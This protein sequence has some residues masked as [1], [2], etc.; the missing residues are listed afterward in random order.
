MYDVDTVIITFFWTYTTR[1]WNSLRTRFCKPV[2]VDHLIDS[3]S[4]YV[5]VCVYDNLNKDKLERSLDQAGEDSPDTLL[6]EHLLDLGTM[7]EEIERESYS[8]KEL[9]LEMRIS[10]HW[11]DSRLNTTYLEETIELEPDAV[12]EFWVPDSYFHHAHKAKTVR[13]M[14]PTASLQVTPNQTIRYTEL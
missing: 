7:K 11:V 10:H 14:N 13:I 9:I 12:T 1:A 4:P 6:C 3:S 8:L 5:R 2:C